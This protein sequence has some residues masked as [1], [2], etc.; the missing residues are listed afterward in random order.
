MLSFGAPS[1]YSDILFPTSYQFN[2]NPDYTLNPEEDKAWE[3]KEHGLYWRGSP[4]GGGRGD[5]EF[6]SVRVL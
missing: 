3:E 1:A 6:G 4:T 2:S 5:K